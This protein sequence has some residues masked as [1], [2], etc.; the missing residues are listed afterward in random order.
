VRGYKHPPGKTS[1]EK[2]FVNC[3]LS[4]GK[5][6]GNEWTLSRKE[7]QRR[8]YLRR[9]GEAVGRDIMREGED[10]KEDGN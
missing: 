6:R 8:H 3:I 7:Y 4:L 2:D 10:K 9:E 1:K 5:E